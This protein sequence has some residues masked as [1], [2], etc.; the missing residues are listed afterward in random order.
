MNYGRAQQIKVRNSEKFISGTFRPDFNHVVPASCVCFSLG[1]EMW[2]SWGSNNKSA[3]IWPH[4]SRVKSIALISGLAQS[5][6]YCVW[7][8][9]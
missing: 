3:N 4:W 6:S 2:S 7:E 9:G 5:V 8:G 1:E